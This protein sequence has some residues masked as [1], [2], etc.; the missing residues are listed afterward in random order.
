MEEIRG[1]N[2][3]TC[4]TVN[5]PVKKWGFPSFT[6]AFILVGF[7]VSGLVIG[8]FI[9]IYVIV[10]L[11]LYVFIVV[12]LSKY[13][14]ENHKRGIENPLTDRLVYG[15]IPK[16]YRQELDFRKAYERKRSE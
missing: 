5:E 16:K 13:M 1:T 7:M 9:G 4:D 2:K 15:T 6:L 8:F 14:T 3:Q 11:F 12:R 10:Y